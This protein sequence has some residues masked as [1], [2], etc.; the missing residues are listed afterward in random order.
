MPKPKSPGPH[1]IDVLIGR[2]IRARRQDLGLSLEALAAELAIT[3]QQ[4][5]KYE[6][7]VNRIRVAT[8][9]D[10]AAALRVPVASL[11][12]S[13]PDAAGLAGLSAKQRDAF[14][15]FLASPHAEEMGAAFCQLPPQVQEQ[16]AQLVRTLADQA[17]PIT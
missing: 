11:W 1:Y 15:A 5:Q 9:F 4:L 2:R 16:L 17:Q 10:I 12:A 13:T 14:A 7:A 6:T 8:L 3:Q